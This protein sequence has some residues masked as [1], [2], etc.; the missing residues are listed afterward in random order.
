MRMGGRR[1]GWGMVV[2]L[3]GAIV[4]LCV[5]LWPT[6][7]LLLDRATRIASVDELDFRGWVSDQTT[8]ST[9][10]RDGLVFHDLTTRRSRHM[11]VKY[12]P[13]GTH[14]NT[15]L[16]PDGQWLLS[17]DS[18]GGDPTIVGTEVQTGHTFSWPNLG[19]VYHLQNCWLS[20]SRHWLQYATLDDGYFTVYSVDQP[21]M[22]TRLDFPDWKL[23]DWRYTDYCL[24]SKNYLLL[25]DNLPG[26]SEVRPSGDP[27]DGTSITVCEYRLLPSTLLLHTYHVS[28]PNGQKMQSAVFSPSGDRIAILCDDTY[29]PPLLVWLH[30]WLPQ[31]PATS[32]QR[33]SLW[34]TRSDGSQP[35]EIGYI[36]I[37]KPDPNGSAD[38][39]DLEWL[40]SG[41]RLSF[42]YEDSVYTVP[43]D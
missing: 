22:A 7:R 30:K 39:A 5:R 24:T 17:Y 42:I 21:H 9:I 4:A 23:H 12:W 3:I 19:D 26:D 37:P 25:Y 8:F 11:P 14:T 38:I 2:A 43:T 15:L 35:Q 31:I 34:I 29:V 40:P 10:A 6:E 13:K 16:S 18:G 28:S 32:Q 27:F 36:A 41:K 33:L 20:D 1:W